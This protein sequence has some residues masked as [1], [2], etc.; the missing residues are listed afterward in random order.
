[1]G[2]CQLLPLFKCKDNHFFDGK[3]ERHDYLTTPNPKFRPT[4]PINHGPRP[5]PHYAHSAPVLHP[6]HKSHTIHTIH[7][8]HKI[9]TSHPS[10][11]NL[12]PPLVCGT[13]RLA[14]PLLGKIF[15]ILLNSIIEAYKGMFLLSFVVVRR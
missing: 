9:H 13:H 3:Q 5:R 1:M 12:R 7:K 11:K 6:P 10:N 8:S 2:H 14:L 15:H 4:L